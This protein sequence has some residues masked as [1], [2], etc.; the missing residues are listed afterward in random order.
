MSQAGQVIYTNGPVESLSGNTGGIVYPIGGNIKITGDSD[1]VVS[2]QTPGD[3]SSGELVI[4]LSGAIPNSMVTNSGTASPALGV[5]NLLGATNISTSSTPNPDHSNSNTINIDLSNSITLP[6]TTSDGLSGVINIGTSNPV[7]QAYGTDNI[8]LGGA[9]NLTLTVASATGN[10]GC[11]KNS[12]ADISTGGLNVALGANSGHQLTTGENNTLISISAGAAYTTESNNVCIANTGTEGD[13]GIIRIGTFGGGAGEQSIAYIAGLVH[14][15]NGL[16]VDDGDFTVS[17]GSVSLNDPQ[18]PIDINFNDGSVAHP[19]TIGGILGRLAFYGND[20]TSSIQAATILSRVAD[21]TSTGAVPGALEFWTYPTGSTGAKR[22]EILDTGNIIIS[23]PDS[24]TALTVSGGG[25]NVGGGLTASGDIV[26]DGVT[27]PSSVSKGDIIAATA[28]DVLGVI[29]G[30]ATSGY[31]LTANGAGTVPTFQAPPTSGIETLAGDSGTATGSTVTLAGGTNIT[32]SATTATVTIDLDDSITL[33]G[34]VTALNVKTS[35]AANNLTMN[36]NTITSDG[37]AGANIDINL[38][39]KGA[40]GLTFDG[41]STGYSDS[42]WHIRQS[43]LQTTDA[44]VTALVSIPLVEGEMIT[45][46]SVIN[47]FQSD[48]TDALGAQVFMTAY[49]PSGGNVT[50]IGEEVINLN[51]TSTANVTADV[52]VST[53]SMVISVN[54]VASETWNW[55]STHQYTFTRTNS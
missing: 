21:Y 8:F 2:N 19:S 30:A 6:A 50:Q 7:M 28:D 39:A 42:Q 22:L 44:T 55:V 32:T 24:G 11:G 3:P 27:Y 13:S 9:G 38:V 35:T 16:T 1:I 34:D 54:G 48:F 52:N 36:G 51:T 17:N 46:T 41:I 53:Q 20:G 5:L 26:L 43:E 47:G 40:G 49:R 29:T 25:I 37:T 18:Y 14:A 12:L 10:V 31:I 23:D 15:T 45:I 4:S 33:T